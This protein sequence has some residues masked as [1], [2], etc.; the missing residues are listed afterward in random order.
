MA[1]GEVCFFQGL[2]ERILWWCRRTKRKTVVKRHLDGLL[3]AWTWSISPVARGSSIDV[4]LQS[5]ILTNEMCLLDTNNYVVMEPA[6]IGN[7]V[8]EIR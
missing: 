8:K 4:D 6:P 1:S 2:L 3:P 7:D 5:D